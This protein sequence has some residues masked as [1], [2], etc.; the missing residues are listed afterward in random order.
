M[1][2]RACNTSKRFIL[3]FM[4]LA[5]V[6]NDG[7]S[8]ELKIG[9]Q[10][11]TEKNLDVSIFKNG[12]TIQQAQ[13]EE[14][15][16]EAIRNYEPA[17]CYVNNDSLQAKLYNYY[18]V[19]D[20]RDLAPKG[21]TIP[22]VEDFIELTEFYGG[23]EGKLNKSDIKYYKK[24]FKKLKRK[25]ERTDNDSLFFLKHN[26][27]ESKQKFREIVPPKLSLNP[28]LN[29]EFL[30]SYTSQIESANVGEVIGPLTH[31]DE[32]SL[33]KI[34]ASEEMEYATV[35]HI[36]LQYKSDEELKIVK[37]RADSLVK[38]INH[39]DNFEQLVEQFSEDPGSI[40][41]GGVYRDFSRG[42]MVKEFNDFTFQN[43]V[44]SI[45]IVQTSFGV[46]IVEIL[47]KR[48][49]SR[50]I[51]VKVTKKMRLSNCP[52]TFMKDKD[53]W[54]SFPKKGKTKNSFMAKPHGYRL[55]NG[56]FHEVGDRAVFWT[57]TVT[58]EGYGYLSLSDGLDVVHLSVTPD[59]Y[60]FSIRCIKTSN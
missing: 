19:S 37:K 6:L 51:I 2:N 21:W 50:P 57:S 47:E 3:V 31:N 20:S 28:S 15:W 1:K 29:S 30:K 44:G 27:I 41:K 8:Q 45:G 10:I 39:E 60:G 5:V 52:A 18:A 46:H 42:T 53:Q 22:T 56:V 16:I 13:S 32:I 34:V 9:N 26:S 11:W 59:A 43:H 23:S 55:T 14:E 58:E 17:W 54:T 25:F 33:I 49:E 36:L 12:D 24:E 4:L 40:S 48:S 38:V 7:F 35:R